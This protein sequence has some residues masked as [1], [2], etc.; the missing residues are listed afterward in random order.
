MNFPHEYGTHM[1]QPYEYG[2]HMNLP[3]EQPVGE[4]EE[5]QI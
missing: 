2:T 4:G 1:K 3:H 5:L